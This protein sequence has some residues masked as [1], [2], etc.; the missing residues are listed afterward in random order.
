MK[1]AVT[2]HTNINITVYIDTDDE[3]AA[4]DES[5]A[6]AEDYLKGIYGDPATAV[7]AEATLDGIGADSVEASP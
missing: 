1:Y 6:V 4:A 7:H 5:W 2:Y 3:E